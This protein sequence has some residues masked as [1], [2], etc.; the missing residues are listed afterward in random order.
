MNCSMPGLPVHH[1]L[2]EFA[3]THVHR[4]SDAIQPSH[5]LSSP[6][7]PAPN[8]S[9]HE[10]FPMSQLFAWGGQS[11]FSIIRPKEIPGLISFRM[12]LL[13]LLAVQ[14]TLKSTHTHNFHLCNRKICIPLFTL[15]NEWEIHLGNSFKEIRW[16]SLFW[17]D[18][19]FSSVFHLVMYL[20]RVEKPT[21]IS[22]PFLPRKIQMLKC[23]FK[24]PPQPECS[25]ITDLSHSQSGWAPRLPV[26]PCDHRFWWDKFLL[27]GQQQRN[28]E[29]DP[30]NQW[31]LW[32]SQR[33]QNSL[34]RAHTSL[35]PPLAPL[36]SDVDAGRFSVLW[37]VSYLKL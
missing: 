5:P 37:F 33:T 15:R 24:T 31:P 14:G 19:T 18:N 23:G 9:Q 22:S 35:Y 34:E 3:Q 7:P 2:L 28:R 17:A 8:P 6:F 10:S 12:D 20:C 4:V 36:R 32:S 21:C 16:F 26:C 25:L 13:D 1:Q 11:S 30:S 29:D 27:K